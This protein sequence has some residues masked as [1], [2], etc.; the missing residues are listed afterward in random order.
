MGLWLPVLLGCSVPLRGRR[1]GLCM[2]FRH[3]VARQLVVLRRGRLVGL[4]MLLRRTFAAAWHC[5]RGARFV[6]LALR[7]LPVVHL[8]PVRSRRTRF[9]SV[10]LNVV[11]LSTWVRFNVIRSRPVRFGLIGRPAKRRCSIRPRLIRFRLIR[12]RPVCLAP[13]FRASILWT[14]ISWISALWSLILLSLRERARRSR[15][16]IVQ[17]ARLDRMYILVGCKG[18]RR[19]ELLRASMV[20]SRKLPAV[21]AG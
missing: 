10:W 3:R 7:R 8:R 1:I 4:R 2:L 15:R 18:S 17:A 9:R 19:C 21:A 6:R 5:V 12:L 14:S 13:I 20:R 11:R 16:Q